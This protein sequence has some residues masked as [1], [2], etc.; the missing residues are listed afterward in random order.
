M[1]I[2]TILDDEFSRDERMNAKEERRRISELLL[3]PMSQFFHRTL[4]SILHRGVNIQLPNMS[5][6]Q[7]AIAAAEVTGDVF[8][9]QTSN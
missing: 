7:N 9:S 3:S 5:S 4:L 6:T 8:S 1:K 2:L